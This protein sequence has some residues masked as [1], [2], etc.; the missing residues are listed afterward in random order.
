MNVV[1]SGHDRLVVK[2]SGKLDESAM[3]EMVTVPPGDSIELDL[4]ELKFINS[5]GIRQFRDWARS[6]RSPVLMLSYC[7]RMFVDQINLIV[8][9]LP[10]H[11]KV[12]S[13]YVPYYNDDSGEEKAV[14]FTRG[15]EFAIVDGKPHITWPD[16]RDSKGN[17][18]EVDIVGDRY[19]NFLK[20]H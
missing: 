20:K 6:L 14:L 15:K 13:F 3:L 2:M 7:P 1:V 4:V 10:P 11:A 18:M 9:F 17:E 5:L 16:V 8:D 12:A 19:F